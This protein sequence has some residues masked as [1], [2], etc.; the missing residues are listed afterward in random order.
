[1]KSHG[2]EGGFTPRCRWGLGRRGGPFRLR[3]RKRRGRLCENS[4]PNSR[5]VVALT[6]GSCLN[7]KIC[8]ASNLL[9]VLTSS[10][11][12]APRRQNRRLGP[13]SASPSRRGRHR[14]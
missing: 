8:A 2:K 4:V 13:S 7:R 5:F 1:E 6:S 11:N 3:S 12:L 10:R 9:R 14:P